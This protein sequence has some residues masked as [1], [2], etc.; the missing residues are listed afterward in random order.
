MENNAKEY[1]FHF[2]YVVEQS[3][4]NAIEAGSLFEYQFVLLNSA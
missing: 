3:T 4:K 1:D 2:M